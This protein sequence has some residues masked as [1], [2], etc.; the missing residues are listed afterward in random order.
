[1]HVTVAVVIHSFSHA[2]P[3]PLFVV[4]ASLMLSVVNVKITEGVGRGI[5]GVGWRYRSVG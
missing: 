1:M 5:F 3:F 2:A 4:G